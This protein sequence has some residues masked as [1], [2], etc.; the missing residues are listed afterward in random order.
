MSL[1]CDPVLLLCFLLSLRVLFSP[2]LPPKVYLLGS[3]IRAPFLCGCAVFV[4]WGCC[5]EV[6]S[7]HPGS[8]GLKSR[9]PRE[10][11]LH[12]KSRE[13][14]PLTAPV[15]SKCSLA[16]LSSYCVPPA[17]AFTAASLTSLSA[18]CKA[19]LSVDERPSEIIHSNLL[20]QRCLIT[21]AKTFFPNEVTVTNPGS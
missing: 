15:D 19:H 13:A 5:T 2:S 4:S 11:V 7:L 1:S 21:S 6:Y 16:H 3:F 20:T 14:R 12:L 9:C 8:Q 10:A 18:S 17:C